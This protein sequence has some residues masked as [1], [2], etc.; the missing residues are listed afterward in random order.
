MRLSIIVN[1]QEQQWRGEE[2]IIGSH[3][4]S[5]VFLASPDIQ[6]QHACLTKH[7]S[8]YT[9]EALSADAFVHGEKGSKRIHLQRGDIAYVG[10][11]SLLVQASED[12]DADAQIV[13]QALEPD[14]FVYARDES[15]SGA[16]TFFSTSKRTWA[17]GLS[18]LSL[19][20]FLALPL[21]SVYSKPYEDTAEKYHLSTDKVWI[22]GDLA[23]AHKSPDIAD[24]C[25]V[26]HQE[27]F[28]QVT[29]QACEQ[30]HSDT[31]DHF[32]EKHA[33]GFAQLGKFFNKQACTDCH[34]EHVDPHPIID[35]SETLCKD[36]HASEETMRALKSNMPAVSGFT[37]EKHPT[38]KY[39]HLMYQQVTGQEHFSW[40]QTQTLAQ[41][42]QPEVSNLKFPHDIHLDSNKVNKENQQALECN[43]CHQQKDK[44]HF[45]PI[46]MEKHC[47]SCHSLQF[48]DVAG[49]RELPHASPSVVIQELAEY[50]ALQYS[51]ASKRK[52]MAYS[53][54]YATRRMPGKNSVAR[55]SVRA[56]G[57]STAACIKNATS[58]EARNQFE[59]TGCVT[60]HEIT[61]DMSKPFKER[62]HVLPVKL[63]QDWYP[64]LKFSH[65][66]HLLGLDKNEQENCLSCHE[67]VQSND[68]QDV[69][70]P[71]IEN[72]VQC[73]QSS[74]GSDNLVPS[75]CV[76]CHT[77]HHTLDSQGDM[78]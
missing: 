75:Q 16:N 22:S 21:L 8:I 10:N 18:L 65:R 67:A 6:A 51:S 2:L 58:Q 39:T 27:P 54:G 34:K 5:D 29:D 71:N 53:R 41:A 70:I 62:W 19:L 33:A 72:C 69:L 64:L 11:Y 37:L 77:Y 48:D 42:N 28:V 59:V 31:Q 73:H 66:S 32:D 23:S 43:D 63:Q 36:C 45:E 17:Y 4:D 44:E 3:P 9:L 24:N 74:H 1:R 20:F 52:D 13:I 56:C 55:A 38:F 76:D 50:F 46:S 57:Q 60:C 12:G 15:A 68:A 7:G 40:Q 47:Q 25:E 14:E 30:C 61:K 78:P 26:C 35:S 49:E